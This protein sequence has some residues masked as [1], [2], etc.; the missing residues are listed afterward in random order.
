[1]AV[2]ATLKVFNEILSTLDAKQHRAAIFELAKILTADLSILLNRP[3]SIGV[4][5]HSLPCF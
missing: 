2:P 4:F 5:S 1:M 3:D